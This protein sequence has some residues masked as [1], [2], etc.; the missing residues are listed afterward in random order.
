MLS[1]V[2]ETAARNGNRLQIDR[3]PLT[4]KF[5]LKGL[6]YA[7]RP[8]TRL[9]SYLPP[10]FSDPVEQRSRHPSWERTQ[11]GRVYE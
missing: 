2:A 6:T 3:T 4:R 10:P 11:E 7:L 1:S 9:R 8:P 5:Q